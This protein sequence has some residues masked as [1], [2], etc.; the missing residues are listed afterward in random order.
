MPN[1]SLIGQS[2]SSLEYRGGV[3]IKRCNNAFA[4]YTWYRDASI[5]GTVDGVRLPHVEWNL[6][7]EPH[8]YSIEY[9]NGENLTQCCTVED[10]DTLIRQLSLWNKVSSR[11]LY[12]VNSYLDRLYCHVKDNHYHPI[13]LEAYNRVVDYMTSESWWRSEC[14]FHHGDLTLENI[15]KERDGTLV[16]LDP[17][18]VSDIWGN[19][20]LDEG[21]LLQSINSD[22]HTLLTSYILKRRKVLLQHLETY[23]NK[24]SYVAELSHWIRLRKYQPPERWSQVD[25]MLNK[26]MEALKNGDY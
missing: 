18:R 19:T 6:S 20:V 17:N 1:K 15:I 21:K 5:I 9:I 22:Y 3:V 25:F 13:I 7:E 16:L 10:I 8:T 14:S 4:Q 11:E 26:L 23:A 12:S 24:C 2:G